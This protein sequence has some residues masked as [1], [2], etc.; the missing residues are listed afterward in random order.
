MIG[1]GAGAIMLERGSA[2]L[3][4]RITF[5]ALVIPLSLLAMALPRAVVEIAR[6]IRRHRRLAA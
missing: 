2:P 1:F 4:V 5:Q 3:T 6:L